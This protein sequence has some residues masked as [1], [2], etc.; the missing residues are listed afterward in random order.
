MG[1]T[2]FH[3]WLSVKIKRTD[4]WAFRFKHRPKMVTLEE[5]LYFFFIFEYKQEALRALPAW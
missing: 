4:V 1:D 3:I 2:S 5:I